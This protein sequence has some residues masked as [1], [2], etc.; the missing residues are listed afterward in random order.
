M[1]R[2]A[3]ETKRQIIKQLNKRVLKETREKRTK[4]ERDWDDREDARNEIYDD[5][6][7]ILKPVLE[8]LYKKHGENDLIDL[9]DAI[10]MVIE[11]WLES[12]AMEDTSGWIDEKWGEWEEDNRRSDGPTKGY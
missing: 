12:D 11:E 1:L 4:E 9:D 5:I 2:K 8:T 7:D 3:N 10:L 6:Y